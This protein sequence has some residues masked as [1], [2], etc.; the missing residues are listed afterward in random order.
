MRKPHLVLL[1]SIGLTWPTPAA[2]AQA[3][4]AGSPESMVRQN[5]VAR[6]HG[7]PFVSSRSELRELLATGSLVQLE[8]NED[9]GPREGRSPLPARPELK[10]FLERLAAGY[11]EATGE[12]LVVTSATR[13]AD[14]QPRNSHPLS[15]HPVGIAVDLRVSRKAAS[16]RWLEETLL[17]ME[18][19]G[20]LDVTRERRPPHYHVALFPGPYLQWLES[21]IAVP[22][23][24]QGPDLHL[25]TAPGT[26]HRD[27]R[28]PGRPLQPDATHE[29]S[30]NPTDPP[31]RGG[32]PGTN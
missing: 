9:Y 5:Q 4:L 10:L 1:A 17:S 28:E 26:R 29:V 23:I 16:R 6:E 12:K 32:A 30:R 21:A 24:P 11:R 15:V 20:L 25:E 14:R 7:L 3:T 13:S 27:P 2:A 22:S 19:Q 8:G 31:A 18:G